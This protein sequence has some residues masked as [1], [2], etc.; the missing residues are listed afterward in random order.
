MNVKLTQFY[1]KLTLEKTQKKTMSAVKGIVLDASILL[2][3]SND[4]NASPS[5]RPDADYV[6]RKLRYSN[7]FT[8]KISTFSC[9]VS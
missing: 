8:V 3:S 1:A 9:F 7:I 5:L 4:E 6:L 2:E